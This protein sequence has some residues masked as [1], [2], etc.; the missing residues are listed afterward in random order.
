MANAS[1]PHLSTHEW[2]ERHPKLAAKFGRETV[3]LILGALL[4][5]ATLLATSLDWA[6]KIPSGASAVVDIA[7]RTDPD[8]STPPAIS[9]DFVDQFFEQKKA[10]KTEELPDQF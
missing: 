3:A 6:Q 8:A 9:N 4:A 10:A 5:I 7:S 2:F 1:R